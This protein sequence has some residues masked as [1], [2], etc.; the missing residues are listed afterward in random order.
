MKF[1]FEPA[2]SEGPLCP[3][4]LSPMSVMAVFNF[5]LVLKVWS[6]IILFL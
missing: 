4:S 3:T 6:G 2:V 1:P 5:L